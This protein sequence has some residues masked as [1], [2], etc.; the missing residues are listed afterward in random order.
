MS[1]MNGKTDRINIR[2][3]ISKYGIYIIFLSIFLILSFASDAFF[4]PTNLINIAKQASTVAIIAIGQTFCLIIGGMDLSSGSIMALAGVTSAMF[5]L[6]DS[7]NM[8]VAFAVALLVGT[9]CGLLNGIVVSKGMVPAFIATLG[10]QQI[11]RGMALLVTNATPVFGLSKTYTFL[12]SGKVAG[13]PMLVIVM[14]I[15]IVIAAFVLNKTKFG[16]HIYAVGGNE[17]S[18]HVSGIHV[19]KVKLLVYTIAGALAG[20]GGLLLAGRIQSGTPTMGE[21][22]ELDAIAGA[23]IG[24][25]STSGGI[26][27]VYGAVIGSLLMAM[28]SNGLDLLNVSAYYQQIS[29]GL[30]IILAVLLDVKTKVRNN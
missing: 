29:K 6:A 18:A 30:I 12:G 21:G 4:T 1:G 19:A 5:G 11:A 28:I 10:M 24:G 14:V 9:A 26:G 13:V 3:V 8:P 20:L 23:V 2:E 27:T 15:N 17:L 22:Y 7:T 16:R 25:V